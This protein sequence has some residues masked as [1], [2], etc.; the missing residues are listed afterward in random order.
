LIGSSLIVIVIVIVRQ[1][2][3]PQLYQTTLGGGGNVLAKLDRRIRVRAIN[4]QPD[5]LILL[6]QR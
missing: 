4:P 2:L 6:F 3:H 1:R 5:G